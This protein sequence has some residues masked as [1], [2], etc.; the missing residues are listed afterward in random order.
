MRI[1]AVSH[2][3]TETPLTENLLHDK[4]KIAQV[5]SRTPLKRVAKPKEMAVTIAF[6]SLNLI[7]I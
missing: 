7:K 3:F 1:N 4:E 5:I 6:L 2:W